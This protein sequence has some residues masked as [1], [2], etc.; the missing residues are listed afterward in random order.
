MPSSESD[1]R[2]KA[3]RPANGAC[4]LLYD[5][6]CGLCQRAV[7]WMVRHDPREH[8]LYAPQQQPLAAE[9]VARH[10]HDPHGTSSA[11]LV[12]N[13]NTPQEKLLLRSN[14]ILGSL[15]VFG[16]RWAILAA[17]ARLVPRV[18]RDIAYDWLARNRHR[19]IADGESCTLPTPAERARS[20]DI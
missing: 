15:G 6:E 17:V 12:L 13:Y 7:R 1:R 9:I 2:E 14:A 20:L 3:P 16:G 10:S 18:P 19:L 4:I 5:G 11:V 8:L